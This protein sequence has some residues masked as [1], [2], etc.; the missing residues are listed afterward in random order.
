MRI[1]QWVWTT[2]KGWSSGGT[3]NHERPPRSPLW[4]MPVF[5]LGVSVDWPAGGRVGAREQFA[6]VNRSASTGVDAVRMRKDS[7]ACPRVQLLCTFWDA[8]GPIPFISVNHRLRFQRPKGPTWSVRTLRAVLPWGFLGHPPETESWGEARPLSLGAGVRAAAWGR[9]AGVSSRSRVE[10]AALLPE[11]ASRP[12]VF[13]MFFPSPAYFHDRLIFYREIC[14][15]VHAKVHTYYRAVRI[16][17]QAA[18]S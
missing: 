16:K 14:A 4:K 13:L 11:I 3:G 17:P 15:V 7:C 18:G 2:V 12:F 6:P 1:S 8:L 5:M 9:Q 10:L